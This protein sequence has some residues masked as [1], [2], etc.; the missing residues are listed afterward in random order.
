M[1]TLTIQVPEGAEGKKVKAV[2]KALGVP[3][4]GGESRKNSSVKKKN[5]E[6]SPY[7]PEYVEMIQRSRKQAR[8]GKTVSIKLEDLWK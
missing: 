7:N 5:K 6:E 2:L 8:E 4:S 1:E 3:M